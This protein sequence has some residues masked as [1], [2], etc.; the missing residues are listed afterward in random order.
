[1][2]KTDIASSESAPDEPQLVLVWIPEQIGPR[3]RSAKYED[4]LDAALK[5]EAVGEVNGG[6]T[7]L[8][9]SNADGTRSI[10]WVGL[11][12]DLS[13]F[14]KGLPILKRELLRLGAPAGTI[15]EYSRNGQKLE[16]RL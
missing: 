9:A 12:V 10:E 5:K 16:E 4:P 3:D 15:L 8:S 6:D 7:R 14:E 1:M 11:D 2:A 13:D